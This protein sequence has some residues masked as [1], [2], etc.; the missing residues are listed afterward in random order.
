VRY[1]FDFKANTLKS[2]KLVRIIGLS[3]GFVIDGSRSEFHVQTIEESVGALSNA[4]ALSPIDYLESFPCRLTSSSYK[5]WHQSSIIDRRSFQRPLVHF[6]FGYEMA[7]GVL[8]GVHL[9]TWRSR[10]FS[11]L[12]EIRG[13]LPDLIISVISSLGT[14]IN[15][16]RWSP[17]TSYWKGS[18]SGPST[19]RL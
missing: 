15:S 12:M 18:S 7:V 17:T 2:I 4:T 9:T 10:A 1:R 3:C 8:Y 11:R 16:Q 19:M 6:S 14:W 13:I 5:Y